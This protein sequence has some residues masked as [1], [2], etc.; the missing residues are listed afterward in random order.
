M[1]LWAASAPTRAGAASAASAGIGGLGLASLT[2]A[3]Q[4]EADA[5][6]QGLLGGALSKDELRARIQALSAQQAAESDSDTA[7]LAASTSRSRRQVTAR[8][9]VSGAAEDVPETAGDGLSERDEG[10]SVASGRAVKGKWDPRASG[11]Q[12]LSAA[13][14]VDELVGPDDDVRTPSTCVPSPW[15]TAAPQLPRDRLCRPP[16][17]RPT[18]AHSVLWVTVGVRRAGTRNSRARCSPTSTRRRSAMPRDA[19]QSSR[20]TH[21]THSTTAWSLTSSRT[22]RRSDRAC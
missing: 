3:H 10:G 8:S 22:P 5:A 4:Q 18:R 14:L 1:A 17:H 21:S 9:R 19:T 16:G 12:P 2:S 7:S 15:C 11:V 13:K 6:T 20:C